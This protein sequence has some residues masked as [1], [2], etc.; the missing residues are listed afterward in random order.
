MKSRK[1]AL[2][3]IITAALLLSGCAAGL[4][5]TGL[6]I[7]T[8]VK[9][10]ITATTATGTKQGTSCATSVLGFVNTGDAS[11]EGA[12]KAG[13]ISTVASADYHTSGAYPFYG[14]TCVIVTGN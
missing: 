5:P 3:A 14:K 13:G 7:Y 6:G 1:L 10:P 12:K 11:I 2:P 4:S 9:G 8:N